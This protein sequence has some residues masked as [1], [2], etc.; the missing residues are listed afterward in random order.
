MHLDVATLRFAFGMAAATML[1]LF[2]FVVYRPT[3]SPYSGWWC[4]AL[5]W[6]LTGAGAL[7][8]GNAREQPWGEPVGNA[9]I[10][11]GAASAWGAARSLSGTTTR[12]WQLTAAPALTGIAALTDDLTPHI[13]AG[14]LVF[15]AMMPL[16]AGLSARELW[17]MDRGFTRTR[18]SVATSATVIC[19]YYAGRFVTFVLEGAD[20]GDFSRYFGHQVTAVFGLVFLV[21]ISFSMSML[22]NEQTTI[23]LRVRATQDGL[24]GILNRTE[25][26][27]RAAH[28]TRLLRSGGANAALILAD[29]DHFKEINDN[30]GHPAGDRVLK[31]FAQ[32]A[33]RTVRSSDLVGRFGGEE[34]ILLLPHSGLDR[35]EQVTS[36]I[37]S[38]LSDLG[39]TVGFPMPSV[40]YGIT[41]IAPRVSLEVAIASADVALYRAKALGRNRAV[42]DDWRADTDVEGGSDDSLSTVD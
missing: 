12:W 4:F 33:T 39:A 25:F 17:H 7:L 15:L 21:V 31:A 3:R 24:T 23:E 10:V 30:H 14:G 41:S 28:E 22:S 1:A 5:T 32:A 34:F 9:L 13:S 16:L 35:A 36:E 27:R 20:G 8:V 42:R 29:L 11:L 38:M 19:I 18:I 37:S 2:Y 6:Y 40:S 26:L